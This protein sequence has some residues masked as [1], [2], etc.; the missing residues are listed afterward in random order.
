MSSL[1]KKI[2]EDSKKVG[3]EAKKA[4]AEAKKDRRKSRFRS[5]ESWRESS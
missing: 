4:G 5:E 1:K 2:E 3:A